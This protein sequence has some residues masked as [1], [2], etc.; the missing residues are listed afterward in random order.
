MGRMTAEKQC[1]QIK[2]SHVY[3]PIPIRDFDWAAWWDGCEEDGQYGYGKTEG[4]AV[5]DLIASYDEPGAQ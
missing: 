4:D 5:A 1:P 2:T 3:P